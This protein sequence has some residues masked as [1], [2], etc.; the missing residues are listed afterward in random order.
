[1]KILRL[2]V[3]VGYYLVLLGFILLAFILIFDNGEEKGVLLLLSLAFVHLVLKLGFKLRK[4]FKNRALKARAF[5]NSHYE[6]SWNPPN[7]GASPSDERV[8]P[9]T[10]SLGMTEEDMLW[11]LGP[12][13]DKEEHVSINKIKIKYYYGAYQKPRGGLAFRKYV[14]VENGLVVGWGDIR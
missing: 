13:D 3:R 8:V 1:M 4:Y 5:D 6:G 2:V 7:F 10:V 11:L 12:A 9:K 14:L